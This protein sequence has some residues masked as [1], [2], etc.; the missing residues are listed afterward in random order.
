MAHTIL[1]L[2][3]GTHSVKAVCLASAYRAFEVKSVDA[4]PLGNDPAVPYL[5]RVKAALGALRARGALAADMCVVA[6]PGEKVSFHTLALPFSDRKKIAQTIAFEIESVVPFDLE[7]IVFDYVVTPG[8]AGGADVQ[9]AV[10]RRDDLRA[11]LG[12]L[13]EVGVDPKVVDLDAGCYLQL[14]GRSFWEDLQD[15]GAREKKRS[16]VV[17]LKRR[18]ETK[19]GAK[20]EVV[21]SGEAETEVQASG[22][23]AD[24][25]AARVAEPAAD[26]A[27]AEGARDTGAVVVVDIGHERTNVCVIERDAE[28]AP[29]LAMARTLRGGGANMVRLVASREG[30][31][32][33]VA[34]VMLG[35]R[36]EVTPAPAA[37]TP[38]AISAEEAPGPLPPAALEG[39]TE[40]PAVALLDSSSLPADLFDATAEAPGAR[41]GRDVDEEREVTAPHLSFGGL[42]VPPPLPGRAQ[43]TAFDSFSVPAGVSIG[44]AVTGPVEGHVSEAVPAAEAAPV[45]PAESAPVPSVRRL[46]DA[47]VAAVAAE[48][49]APLV[50]VLFLTLHGWRAGT[51]ASEGGA[52]RVERVWVTGG[53]TQVPGVIEVVA[54]GVPFPVA[55]LPPPAALDDDRAATGPMQKSMSL[56]LREVGGGPAQS[57]FNVR[58]GEFAFKGSFAFVRERLAR[59]AVAALVLMVLAGVSSYTQAYL[60]QSTEKKLDGR[61]ADFSRDVLGNPTTNYDWVL[62]EMQRRGDPHTS[63]VIPPVSAVD[64]LNEVWNH[65]P[66]GVTIDLEELDISLGKVRLKG[67]TNSFEAVD[68]FKSSLQGYHCFSDI[69]Q[70]NTKSRQTGVEFSLSMNVTCGGVA[71]E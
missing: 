31:D 25:M 57:R 16:K 56:A 41:E 36:T 12:V 24:A 46:S 70:G 18:K 28:G 14:A 20:L 64:I 40:V 50:R 5:D 66:K 69:K 39:A 33:A 49:L 30:V 63:S 10:V 26:G 17:L 8:P 65:I 62:V 21:G 6:A 67:E 60:L 4:E 22:E 71:P 42:S 43:W 23:V 29:H 34:L 48:A 68:S 13:A 58:V 19:G 52:R 54:E 2:D 1:G 55:L 51:P 61:L 15:D 53:T 3:L 9:V 35:W 11:L 47:E 27:P 37:A 38:E 45:G 44:E 32:E 7:D 59:L